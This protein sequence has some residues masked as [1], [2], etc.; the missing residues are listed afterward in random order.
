[1]KNIEIFD[2]AMCCST[3]VCGP[4]IDPELLR[5]ATV[6]NSLKEKGIII[7]RHG[8]SNEPQAFISN[9]AISEILQKEGADILPVT[10]VDGEIVKT[11]SYPTNEELSVWL[12]VEINTK[13]Q[14]KGGCCS[15]P[16]G[17]C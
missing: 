10:L 14:K 15:G 1:M 7:K 2:P 16:K 3:G 8:L 4:S 13:P 17:C 9:K 5:V 11:K 12:G 6:I